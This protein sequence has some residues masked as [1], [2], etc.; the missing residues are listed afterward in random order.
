MTKKKNFDIFFCR[1]GSEFTSTY[2]VCLGT[3]TGGVAISISY[4]FLF[5]SATVGFLV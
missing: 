2:V 5:K 3:K 4:L 1:D